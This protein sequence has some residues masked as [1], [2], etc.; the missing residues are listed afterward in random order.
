M[1]RDLAIAESVEVRCLVDKTMPAGDQGEVPN[2]DETLNRTNQE[3]LYT[4]KK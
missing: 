4:R 2:R 3:T 1:T